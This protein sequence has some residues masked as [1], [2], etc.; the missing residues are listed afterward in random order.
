VIDA[1]AS[2]T[3]A[4]TPLA[5]AE[6]DCHRAWERQVPLIVEAPPAL[7]SDDVDELVELGLRT[8]AT[9]GEPQGALER[10]ADRWDDGALGAPDLFPAKGRIGSP[11]IASDI[12]LRPAAVEWL[13]Q[14]TLRPALE[15]YFTSVRAHLADGVWT[16]GICPFCGAPPGFADVVE[17]GVRKLV[18]HLCGAVWRFSRT[19][20]PFCGSVASNDLVRLELGEKEAGYFVAACKACSAYIKELDRRMRWNGGPALVED[21]GSPHFDLVA[22]REGYWRPGGGVVQLAPR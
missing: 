6:R 9:V 7:A 12:G 5:L 20:C 3:V 22:Q 16:L 15:R 11:A 4:I 2:V 10:F 19:R 17:D 14:L 18:C 1:W 13:A 21:W 8:L